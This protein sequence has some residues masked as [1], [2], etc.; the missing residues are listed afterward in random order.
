MTAAACLREASSSPV[1]LGFVRVDSRREARRLLRS[2]CDQ[3]K[4]MIAHHHWVNNDQ[5]RI[6]TH[7]ERE[8]ERERENQTDMGGTESSARLRRLA[9]NTAR[10][11]AAAA[12]CC[13]L[14][15]LRACSA[16][17]G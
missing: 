9:S 15:A 16:A 10:R 12:S 3:I 7:T 11:L 14:T 8:R 2:T 6:H 5:S 13:A 4:Y 1:P 17:V